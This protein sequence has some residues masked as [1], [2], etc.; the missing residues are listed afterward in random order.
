MSLIVVP[1]VPYGIND[2]DLEGMDPRKLRLEPKVRAQA[3]HNQRLM[4][5]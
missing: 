2:F 4:L 1:Q 3:L 5:K